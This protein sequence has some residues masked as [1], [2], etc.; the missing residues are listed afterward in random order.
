M[1]NNPHKISEGSSIKGMIIPIVIVFL[2]VI[3]IVWGAIKYDAHKVAKEINMPS[4]ETAMLCTTDMATQFHIH[5]ELKIVIDGVEQAIPSE[6]GITDGCMHPLHT[7]DTT[8]KIHVESPVK[9]DFTLG[10]LFAVWNKPFD[11]THILDK[12]TDATH[13]IEVT[14]NDKP[15]TTFENT[16]LVDLDKIVITYR[17]NK[18]K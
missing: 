2:V 18:V 16:V 5:P 4:R 17:E 12:T 11:A 8:G 14:I 10:D 1:Y 3:G 7:H 13:V 9:K 6:I 15:V